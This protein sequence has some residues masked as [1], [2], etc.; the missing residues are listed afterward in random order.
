MVRSKI[1]P[2][3]VFLY[4]ILTVLAL[5]FLMP[6]YMAAVTALK[7]PADIS[8][9]SAWELP[10]VF[11]WASFSEAIELLRPN[12]INS[13]ILTICATFGST[14]LGSLNGYVFSKWKFKGSDIVFTLFLF[15]MFIPYQVIL[16]PLFQ[17]LRAMNLYGGLPGLILAHI[18]YGLP[19]TSL[20]FRNFYAQ[21][22]TALIESARLDG[23]G[24][25][26]IYLRIVFP[27]SIPGFVVTSL[28]QFTQIWNEFLWGICLTRHADNP[29]TVGLAQLAGGQAVSWNLP[30]AGSIMAAVPVLCIYIFLGRYFIRGLLAGSVKE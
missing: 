7:M 18:V 22:P 2:G 16:I 9:P 3:S 1:T 4:S 21:I 5:F 12:F 6:A 8:L 13:I 25:F 26:S 29:I 11:N 14:M 27:L 28:W 17:T 20:I 19:I 15:G 10:P 24:F 23:A 30:M